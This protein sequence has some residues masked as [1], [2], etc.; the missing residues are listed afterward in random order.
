MDVVPRNI[1]CGIICNKKQ[2]LSIIK[3]HLLNPLIHQLIPM[4]YQ[5]L[6]PLL[7]SQ[8][9]EQ[10]DDGFRGVEGRQTFQHPY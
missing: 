9:D 10:R 2:I 8:V 7:Y 6:S 4:I 3:V 1:K 5:S